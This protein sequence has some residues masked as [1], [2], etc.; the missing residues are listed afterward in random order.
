MLSAL[1]SILFRPLFLSASRIVLVA[2]V[3]LFLSSVGFA[4]ADPVAP[5]LP[6][7]DIVSRLML[8][9]AERTASL[10]RFTSMRSYDVS[11]NGIAHKQ[12]NMKVTANYDH[13]HKTFSIV[14]ESGSKL[15]LDHVLHKLLTSEQ[16][17]D[18][19]RSETA[20]TRDNYDFALVGSESKDGR[21]CYVLAVTP[22]RKNKYLYNGKIWVDAEDFAVTHVEAHPAVNPSFWISGTD[23]EHRYEKVG[24]FWLPLSN[25]SVTKVRIGGQAVLTITYGDYKVNP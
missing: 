14:S 3:L 9:N 5:A 24:E 25:R 4:D 1:E 13:G 10:A 11:Y 15:L 6:V 20:L 8:R 23:I 18:T 17:A 19:T 21:T 22:T 2:G 7:N 12:A 16:E